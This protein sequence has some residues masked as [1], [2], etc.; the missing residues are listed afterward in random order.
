MAGQMTLNLLVIGL[1]VL[2]PLAVYYFSFHKK[3]K[4]LENEV[5]NFVREKYK[6]EII[7]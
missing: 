5:V 6:D 3:I 2:V 4:V 7:N 1:G